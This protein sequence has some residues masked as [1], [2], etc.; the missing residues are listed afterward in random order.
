MPA[1]SSNQ[2]HMQCIVGPAGQLQL[3]VEQVET[4][5]CPVTF[6]MCHPHPLFQG[7]MDN[8]VVTTLTK[9]FNRLGVKTI[10]FNYRG[11]GQS[12]GRYD[13]GVGETEDTI[14]VI[15]WARQQD[16]QHEI[17]LGGFSFGGYI[18]YRA[19][20]Q[21][22]VKQ[23]LTLA[24]GVASHDV[25]NLPEPS[26]PW[27]VVHSQLDEII[28]IQSVLDWL[29]KHDTAYD[30]I[31]FSDASHFFHGQLIALRNKLAPI[32]QARLPV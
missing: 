8:K 5:R 10:R 31:K 3:V 14:A 20:G 32:Y 25:S 28:P 30:F 22:D 19:A 9:M 16:P 21:C 18:A 1:L 11:V 13:R 4:G 6:V 12:E 17:W 27:V 29:A 7:T 24:P 2:N 26:M 23:L 15:E